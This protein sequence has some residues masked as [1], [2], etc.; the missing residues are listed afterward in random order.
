M[1]WKQ[2]FCK[3]VWK[4]DEDEYLR[5]ETTCS[6]A[7]ASVDIDYYNVHALH[8]HCIKC[9]KTQIVERWHLNPFPGLRHLGG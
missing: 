6:N 4:T 1:T 8:Q 2:L 7:G 9:N 5:E 3:H